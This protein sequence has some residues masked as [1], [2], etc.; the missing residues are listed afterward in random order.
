MRFCRRYN[1]QKEFSP[2]G[3][4]YAGQ[5]SQHPPQIDVPKQTGL[6]DASKIERKRLFSA[7]SSTFLASVCFRASCS[8]LNWD[9]IISPC[10]QH[11]SIYFT[12]L[13]IVS[14]G[15]RLAG[16]SILSQSTFRMFGI[17]A[18]YLLQSTPNFS[19]MLV[20]S[21]MS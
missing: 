1:W 4:L 3:Y 16:P 19:T 2:H 9:S 11:H 15:N 13:R 21:S 5:V 17:S 6:G 10:I 20:Q 14:A 7:N 18:S 8:C 12:T